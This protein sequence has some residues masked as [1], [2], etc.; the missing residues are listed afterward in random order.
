MQGSSRW[1]APC[2]GA[3]VRAGRAPLRPAA[4]RQGIARALRSRQM[5]ESDADA[6]PASNNPFHR[7]LRR[8]INV[9]PAEAP[10]LGWGWLYIFSV[11]ASY[12]ILRPI[13]DQMAVA[14]GWDKLPSL[15]TCQFIARP[16]LNVPSPALAKCLPRRP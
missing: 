14:G 6:A 13:P 16:A 12:Y 9:T 4:H 11:L 15:V 3:G 10:A 2:P 8:L 5:T 7:L 1:R